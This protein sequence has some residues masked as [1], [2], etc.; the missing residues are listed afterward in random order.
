MAY[1]FQR[2]DLQILLADLPEDPK[3]ALI[4][5]CGRVE[6]TVSSM[7][8]DEE[9]ETNED[10]ILVRECI[11]VVKRWCEKHQLPVPEEESGDLRDVW[12]K[13]HAGIM[14]ALKA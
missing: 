5:I 1:G 7:E 14:S 8:G 9:Y 3:A 4:E 13:M 6:Q 2:L 11:H 10:Y 12:K